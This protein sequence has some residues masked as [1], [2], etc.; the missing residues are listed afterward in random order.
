MIIGYRSGFNTDAQLATALDMVTTVQDPDLGPLRMPNVLFRMSE[1]PGSIRTVG[2]ASLGAD[3]DE[4][5]T[6]HGLAADEIARLRARG[7]VA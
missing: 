5:L 1:T 4:V 6:E 2:R 3:T 7:V